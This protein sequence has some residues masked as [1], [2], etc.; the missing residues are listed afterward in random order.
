[1][2]TDTIRLDVK[3]A[4]GRLSIIVWTLLFSGS[5]I[6]VYINYLSATFSRFGFAYRPPSPAIL[7]YAFVAVLVP[8]FILPRTIERVTD[9]V[10]WML[11]FGLYISVIIFPVLQGDLGRT[12]QFRLVTSLFASF[13]IILA[14]V[15]FWNPSLATLSKSVSIDARSF[16]QLFFFA[17]ALLNIFVIAVFGSHL[18][19]VGLEQIYEQRAEASDVQATSLVGYAT[20][21]LAGAFNPFLIALGLCRPKKKLLLAI[22]VVGQ[23]LIFA[24]AAAKI[25]LISSAITPVLYYLVVRKG[26]LENVGL[27]FGGGA[28][29]LWV[30]LNVIGTD[31][32]IL[33]TI[34]SLTFM[35]AFCITGVAMAFYTTFFLEHPLTHFSHIQVM[36]NFI[37]YPYPDS[38]GEVI[39]R[40]MAPGTTLDANASFWATDGMAALGFTGI[41]LAGVLFRLAFR[42]F[43]GLAQKSDIRIACVA[44]VPLLMSVTNSSLFTSMF[45]GGGGALLVLLYAWSRAENHTID[46]QSLIS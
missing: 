36:R 27:I 10:H 6:D 42:L 3:P 26:A 5:C 13:L 23:L 34:V 41:V 44:I 29:G 8:A 22:G 19:L 9:F 28:C 43:D 7:A 32:F 33:Q 14:P 21:I 38:V 24:T 15:R 2:T 11:Y 20:G 17:Y 4:L 35:R 16:W 25:V 30:A 37:H 1:M 46:S 40:Y 12:D 18:K 39:G 45:S 31:N